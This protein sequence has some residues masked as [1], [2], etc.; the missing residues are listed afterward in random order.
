[1]DGEARF[2]GLLFSEM[3]KRLCRDRMGFAHEV[4]LLA[5][6]FVTLVRPCVSRPHTRVAAR[7]RPFALW[8]RPHSEA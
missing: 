7:A 6:L 3:D 8:H 1:M 5:S 2:P 4:H